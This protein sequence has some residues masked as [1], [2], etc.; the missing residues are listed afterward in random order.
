MLKASLFKYRHIKT[1]DNLYSSSYDF[2][3]QCIEV[4]FFPIS[5]FNKWNSFGY[6]DNVWQCIRTK[7]FKTHFLKWRIRTNMA[8]ALTAGISKRMFNF[9]NTPSFLVEHGIV[10]YTPDR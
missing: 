8:T 10:Q 4:F 9:I 6:L 7:I 1:G 2:T 3:F 5:K